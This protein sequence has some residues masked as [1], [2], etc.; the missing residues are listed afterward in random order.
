MLNYFSQWDDFINKTAALV[1]LLVGGLIIL[2]SINSNIGIIKQK[3]LISE[4]SNYLKE[5]P[6]IKRPIAIELQGTAMTISAIKSNISVDRKAQSTDEKIEYLQERINEVSRE[7]EQESK[8]LNKKIDHLTNNMST[9]I[10]DAK[11]S[12]RGLE[13]KMD[14]VYTGDL[15]VQLFGV[16]L[17]IYGAIAGYAV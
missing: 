3:S 15:K 1:S 7:L 5:F 12:L 16:L 4:L 8:E 9:Q 14:E 17:I 11:T 13:S 6:L 2:Y 10:Q